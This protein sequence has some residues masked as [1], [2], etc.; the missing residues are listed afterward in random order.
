[1]ASA[2]RILIMPK[3]TWNAEVEYEMLDLVFNGGASWLAKK[4]VVGVEPTEANTEHWMKMCEGADLTEIYNRLSA[5]ETA[6]SNQVAP[7]S[8]DDLD[9]SG[10][11][12]KEEVNGI[13]DDVDTLKDNVSSLTDK[14]DTLESNVEGL[15]EAVSELQTSM[16]GFGASN[17]NFSKRNELDYTKVVTTIDF[18]YAC[19]SAGEVTIFVKPTGTSAVFRVDK[20]SRPAAYFSGDTNMASTFPVAKGD[21]INRNGTAGNVETA[22]ITFVPY[23]YQ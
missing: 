6:L 11:A 10:Y 2:G 21:E 16:E 15:S 14:A 5:L 12:L 9:L 20:N 3:G 1:M 8:L 13:K 4:T 18:P 23:K 17:E 22:T 7:V 19:P